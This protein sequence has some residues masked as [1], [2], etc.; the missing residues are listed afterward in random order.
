MKRLLSWIVMAPITAV[1]IVFTAENL[2]EVEVG[3][4]PLAGKVTVPLYL[5]ALLCIL[6]GFI[7]GGVVAWISGGRRRKRAREMANR[8]ALLLRQ[9]EELR[10]E[11]AA[12]QA[13]AA[14]ASRP[15]Q[16]LT[17]ASGG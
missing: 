6:F 3:V 4:W 12:A 10:R 2:Q 11:Q 9:I 15:P 14:D 8:N 13:R 5:V 7:A 17:S 1:V 16:R